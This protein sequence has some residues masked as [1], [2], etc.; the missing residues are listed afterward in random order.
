MITEFRYIVYEVAPT[1]EVTVLA[2]FNLYQLCLIY[3]RSLRKHDPAWTIN[4]WDN[5]TDKQIDI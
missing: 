1:C 5:L 4:V 2:G 3:V